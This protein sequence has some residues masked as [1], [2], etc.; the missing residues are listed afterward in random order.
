MAEALTTRFPIPQHGGGWM[1]LVWVPQMLSVDGAQ[2][3]RADPATR[4]GTALSPCAM[5][6]AWTQAASQPLTWGP[7]SEDTPWQTAPLQCPLSNKLGLFHPQPQHSCSTSGAS[8]QKIYIK[9][10]MYSPF[11]CRLQ[12]EVCVLLQ[13]VVCGLLPAAP[14]PAVPR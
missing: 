8:R 3:L 14:S 2:G 4:A 1:P 6:R 12:A 11:L 10:C 9:I 5:L 7:P 13:G